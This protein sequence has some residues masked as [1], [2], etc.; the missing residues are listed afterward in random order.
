MDNANGSASAARGTKPSTRSQALGWLT[1]AMLVTVVLLMGFGLPNDDPK[2][3]A[4]GIVPAGG[5]QV[6]FEIG[7]DDPRNP[8]GCGHVIP[9]QQ[10][11]VP[12]PSVQ[13]RRWVS[14]VLPPE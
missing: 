11:Q 14:S 2:Q 10:R 4:T 3:E 1:V 8:T 13:A 12:Q 7:K 5:G 9:H 6:T